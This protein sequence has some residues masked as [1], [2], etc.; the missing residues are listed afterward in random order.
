MGGNPWPVKRFA[1]GRGA[2]LAF[3]ILTTPVKGKF[4]VAGKFLSDR[5]REVREPLPV[6][7]E[8][9]ADRVTVGNRSRER[10]PLP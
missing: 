10:N 1:I 9:S 3:N 2:R 7:V 4:R 5:R 6:R 8:E